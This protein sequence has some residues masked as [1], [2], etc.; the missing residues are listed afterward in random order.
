MV[1]D[2]RILS[3]TTLFCFLASSNHLIKGSGRTV[4]EFW[5]ILVNFGELKNT[6]NRDRNES[7]VPPI[8][9]RFK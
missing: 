7:T 6:K 3:S 5:W 2:R 9:S 4:T 1:I 8:D